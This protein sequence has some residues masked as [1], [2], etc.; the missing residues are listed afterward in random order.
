MGDCASAMQTTSKKKENWFKRQK[1]PMEVAETFADHVDVT[2]QMVDKLV[3]VKEKDLKTEGAS[4]RP[5]NELKL[6]LLKAMKHNIESTQDLI[7]Q[8]ANS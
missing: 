5:R 1:D 4:E 8:Y 6:N 2:E 3:G 7:R